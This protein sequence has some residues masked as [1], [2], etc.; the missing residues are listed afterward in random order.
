MG[1]ALMD[2]GHSLLSVFCTAVYKPA[3]R[4]YPKLK[5]QC[6]NQA[7]LGLS[8]MWRQIKI[9]EASL[10]TKDAQLWK[11]LMYSKCTY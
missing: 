8:V 11:R 1:Q 4:R 3:R 2:C 7:L 9:H 5:D 10:L 6:W